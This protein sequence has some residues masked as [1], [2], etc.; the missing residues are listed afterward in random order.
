MSEQYS[1]KVE[2]EMAA[3]DIRKGRLHVRLTNYGAT[4]MAIYAPDRS[5]RL[6]SVVAGFSEPK[7]YLSDHPYFGCVVGRFTN[8]ISNGRVV[9]DEKTVQLTCN[10][11]N[12]Q[13]HGGFEGFNRKMWTVADSGIDF[14]SFTYRSADGEE[15][16]PGN[17]D[18]T[19]R[20]SLLNDQQLRIDFSAVT[21]Q[22]TVVG[23]TNHTYFNLSGFDSPTIYDHELAINAESYTVKNKENTASG[24]IRSVRGGAL[25]FSLAKKI[26]RDISQLKDDLGYDHNY[27][28]KENGGLAAT[29]YD[30]LSGRLLNVY[31]DQPGLQVYS[32]NWFDGSLSGVQHKPYVQHG[33]VALET[34][35]LPDSPNHPS[36]PSVVLR[37]GEIYKRFTIFEFRTK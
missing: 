18:V 7:E 21:D 33:A 30:P 22:A 12:K 11:G 35:A 20:Y 37:P 4:I 6:A 36:F 3:F 9:I 10:E 25:D 29:L 15:G 5:G 17:L 24:E 13:L 1:G 19:V 28:L 32:A 8:R 2:V 31:T 27:V 34:Q 14:M 26:G 23:L 16:Y